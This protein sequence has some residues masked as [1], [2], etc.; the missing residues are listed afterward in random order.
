MTENLIFESN[1][2]QI[3]NVCFDYWMENLSPAEFKVLMCICRKTLGYHRPSDNLSLSQIM[4]LTGLSRGGVINSIEKL[5][6]VQLI[7]RSRNQ[8]AEHGCEATTYKIKVHSKG[9]PL[10]EKELK[11]KQPS[12]LSRRGPSKLSEPG[13][14]HSVDR[15]KKEELK[16]EEQQ[17]EVVVEK[18]PLKNKV[19]VS[20]P[21]PK[22]PII[23]CLENIP[24][25]PEESAR[26]L[27]KLY[28]EEKLEEAVEKMKASKTPVENPFGW[29]RSCIQE[30]YK[31]PPNSEEIVRKNR[32]KWDDRFTRLEDKTIAGTTISVGNKYVEF[33]RGG[34]AGCGDYFNWDDPHFIEKVELLLEKLNALE[35]GL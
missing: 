30:D 34:A 9:K 28:P 11:N 32:R 22:E 29:L 25:L 2:T 12:K 33:Y 8:S 4:K 31:L 16:K 13:L 17:Q 10:E 7:T 18:T 14:V 23:P 21:K 26:Q 5:E 20:T 3:P 1:Y 24:G 35:K 19:V 6:S 27:M 15:Q